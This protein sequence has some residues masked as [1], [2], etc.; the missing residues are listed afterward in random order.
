M[1]TKSMDSWVVGKERIFVLSKTIFFLSLSSIHGSIDA[2]SIGSKK[3][4]AGP[5]LLKG[6]QYSWWNDFWSK[7]IK[8]FSLSPGTVFVNGFIT[9]HSNEIFLSWVK[10]PIPLQKPPFKKMTQGII[11]YK[12]EQKTKIIPTSKNVYFLKIFSRDYSKKK[13]RNSC[14]ISWILLS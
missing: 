3:T 1:K 2:N 13:G 7:E 6:Y 12:C 11:S 14:N 5:I 8:S 10:A 4:F 9:E